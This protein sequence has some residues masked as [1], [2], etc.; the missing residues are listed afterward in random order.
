M[1]I[2]N[3]RKGPDAPDRP[4]HE[5]HL[6]ITVPRSTKR[7]LKMEAARNGSTMRACVLRGLAAIGIHVPSG[8]LPGGKDGR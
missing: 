7:S 2:M 1:R 5:E 3:V 8:E 4:E 6:Q